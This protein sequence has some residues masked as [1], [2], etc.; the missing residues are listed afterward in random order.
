MRP[1]FLFG[2]SAI[3]PAVWISVSV[4]LGLLIPGQRLGIVGTA[5]LFM[6]VASLISWLFAKRH[7]RHFTK[8]EYWR[9]ILYCYL[10]AVSLELF[11]LFAVVVLPQI[12]TGNVDMKPLAF[13]IPFTLIL[14]GL[15]VWLAFRQGGRR[16]IDAYLAKAT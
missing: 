3:L 12:E 14:D 4:L 1:P 2:Y 5:L 13:A 15:M 9:I 6:G 7:R 11:V 10:W 16:T 8:T